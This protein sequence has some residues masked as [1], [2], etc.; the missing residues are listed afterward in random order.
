M[1][2]AC[3][4][5]TSFQHAVDQVK[6]RVPF[7]TTLAIEHALRDVSDNSSAMINRIR[8]I[9]IYWFTAVLVLCNDIF[10]NRWPSELN[11]LKQ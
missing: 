9:P 4:S 3:P 11:A 10:I 7:V 6:Q 8:C 5:A 2:G 1:S